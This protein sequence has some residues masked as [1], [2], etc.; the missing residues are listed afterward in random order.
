MSRSTDLYTRRAESYAIGRPEYPPDALM[1]LTAIVGVAPPAEIADIGSGTGI[2]TG[3][4][5]G[6]GYHVYAVEPNEAMRLVADR[7]HLGH[8]GYRSVAAAAERTGLPDQSVDAITV[9]QSLHWFDLAQVRVEFARILRPGGGLLALWNEMRCRNC[10]FCQALEG[11]LISLLPAY[12]AARAQAPDPVELVTA[13]MPPGTSI[14]PSH[15]RHEQHVTEEGLWHRIHST[16]YAPERG[17][18]LAEQLRHA[19]A[20]LF[21]EHA[22]DGLVTLHYT[23]TVITAV[24]PGSKGV[25]P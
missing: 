19:L 6:L 9:G 15:L 7:V 20:V 1:P 16:S 5:L 21:R 23:T 11:V 18:P 13:A 14:H 4:L 3:S 2:L 25:R 10:A 22:A 12:A 24:P 8:R 17:D